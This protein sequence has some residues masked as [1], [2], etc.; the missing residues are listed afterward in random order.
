MTNWM[1]VM[2]ILMV[3]FSHSEG[4]ELRQ[5]EELE[6]GQQ[7]M[8]VALLGSE[9]VSFSF[10]C[11]FLPFFKHSCFTKHFWVATIFKLCS[12]VCRTKSEK[13]YWLTFNG[14]KRKFG[15]NENIYMQLFKN[16]ALIVL[17]GF[18]FIKLG[19]LVYFWNVMVKAKVFRKSWESYPTCCS[20]SK[21]DKFPQTPPHTKG[22]NVSKISSFPENKCL[23]KKYSDEIINI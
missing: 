6:R 12:V 4:R 16:I 2:G 18:V 22:G 17:D 15:R 5:L 23:N 3:W 1:G 8:L 20:S 9:I 21:L 11:S 19:C 13:I 10:V 14:R 7:G